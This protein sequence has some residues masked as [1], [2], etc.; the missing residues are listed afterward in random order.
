MAHAYD[1]GAVTGALTRSS[2]Q[3]PERPVTMSPA[4]LLV[5]CF[6]D[7][8]DGQWLAFSLEFGLAAQASTV[9]EVRA[10]LESQI[11][12]Y[13]YDALVGEDRDHAYE[14]MTRRAPWQV[15]ARY[16]FY[17]ALLWL[18]GRSDGRAVYHEPV[19]LEP[20][21]GACPA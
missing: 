11:V 6:T 16:Y 12:S 10:K 5:R 9:A 4:R 8:V 14:L 17:S 18:K 20:H 7:Y 15:Y 13:V 19:P 2:G 3:L 21:L 1:G